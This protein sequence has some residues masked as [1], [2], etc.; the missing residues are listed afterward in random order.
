MV[1]TVAVIT[2][3]TGDKRLRDSVLSVQQQSTEAKIQHWIVVDGP[4]YEAKTRRLLDKMEAC[5]NP[6]IQQRVMVLPENTGA[7]GYVCHRIVGS[8]PWIV[9]TKFVCFLDEDNSFESNHIELL[10]SALNA[11]PGARWAFSFRKIVSQNRDICI[12]LCESLGSVSH[13]CIDRND[14]LIDTNCYLL[15]REL[16]IQISSLWNVK[17]RDP[18]SIE[19]DRSV[20]QTLLR[21][22]PLHAVSRAATVRYSTSNR[23]DSVESSFFLEGNDAFCHGVH[24][25]RLERNDLYLFFFDARRTA[26]YCHGTENPFPLD[27]W[28]PGMLHGI[29][30]KFNVLD[31]FA[32]VQYIPLNALCVVVMCSPETLPL[33]ILEKR[34]DLQKILF[35]VEGPNIRHRRQWEKR[36]LCAHFSMVA[37]YWE[38]LLRDASVPTVFWPHNS[39]FLSFPE[40]QH[41]LRTNRGDNRKS[42]MMVLQNR[43]CSETY[44]IDGVRLTCLDWMREYF[45]SGLTKNLTICGDGWERFCT[46]HPGVKLARNGQR[47]L[48]TKTAIDYYQQSDFS[49]IIENCDA[50]GYVSEKIADAFIAGS[51]PLYLGNPSALVHLPKDCYIDIRPFIEN[52]NALQEFLDTMSEVDVIT[53]KKNICHKRQGFLSAR[54]RMAVLDSLEEGIRLMNS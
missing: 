6:L 17:A 39:R 10:L 9:G 40:H 46:E 42:I 20:C 31:G 37:T 15:E 32:N 24:G 44:C 51:I 4:E 36:F 35:T 34:K 41:L 12:D 11:S 29:T 38:P 23:T 3:T 54:G 27:E 48:D 5:K 45:A 1:D 28:C 30:D 50:H 21:H 26:V 13:T 7:S 47:H 22:E 16:A 8:I 2:A 53:M 18:A 52:P 49:L 19:A 14:R 43:S 25:L 33:E